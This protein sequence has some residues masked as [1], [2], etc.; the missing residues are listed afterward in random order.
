MKTSAFHPQSNAI[1][2]RL[3]RSLNKGLSHHVDASNINWDKL[4]QFYLTAHRDTPHTTMGFCPFFLLHGREIN[5]HSS[6]DVKAKLTKEVRNSDHS[7][8]LEIVKSSLK[9][10]YQSVKKTNKK[11]H[12]KNKR[13]YDR[14]AKRRSFD[15]GDLVYLYNQARKPGLCRKFHKPLTGILRYPA[16]CLT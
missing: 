1:I 9:L 2:E 3:H 10:A 12:L 7:H 16:N 13:L 6:E 4:V 11:S 5:L 8:R 15:I 14:N